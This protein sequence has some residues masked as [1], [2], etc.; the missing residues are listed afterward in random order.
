MRHHLSNLQSTL[1]SGWIALKKIRFVPR[2]AANGSIAR[3]SLAYVHASTRYIQQ[4]SGLL[5]AGVTTLRNSSSSYEV[6]QG[7]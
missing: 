6:V 1:S 3:Q 5:K 7:M 4:V 2:M